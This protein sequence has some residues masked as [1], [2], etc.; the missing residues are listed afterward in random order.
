MDVREI[1]RQIRAGESDHAI[2]R[3]LGV[4]RT[5]VKKYREWAVDQGLLE[6]ELPPV[7]ELQV[8]L[9]ATMPVLPPPRQISSVEPYRTQVEKL[10]AEGLRI[11]AIYARLQEQGFEG[12]YAAVQRFVRRLEPLAVDVT[13]R[14]E[15][16]P[17]EEAQV[18]FGY[19]GYML[20]EAK[21]RR[22]AWVFV[23]TLSY[24]RHQYVEFV[25]DQ[26]VDTWLSISLF[27]SVMWA[28][29]PAMASWIRATASVNSATALTT[30]NTADSTETSWPLP[31]LVFSFASVI[32]FS[33]EYII[34]TSTKACDCYSPHTRIVPSLRAIAINV[35]SGLQ[36]KELTP[37]TGIV[38]SCS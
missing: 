27:N 21:H 25:F 6:G 29:I 26:R 4:H 2:R 28:S 7:E 23:M 13:V 34:N 9:N 36:V 17:G 33:S 14:V 37:L 38:A 8:R 12:T 15:R 18:D 31:I 20:D 5:T 16:A 3:N 10:R 24:S 32:L 19:A 22:K 1:L 30:S 35:P 11:S